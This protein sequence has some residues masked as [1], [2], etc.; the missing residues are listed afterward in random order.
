MTSW[1]P[2]QGQDYVGL[3]LSSSHVVQYREKGD[4]KMD[5]QNFFTNI[6]AGIACTAICAAIKRF[7]LYVKAS[8]EEINSPKNPSP[9]KTLQRQ[10]LVA[11]FLLALSLPAAF[12]LPVSRR[13]TMLGFIR[14]FLFF[15]AG[16]AFLIVWGAFDA[17]I[18]FYPGEDPRDDKPP[19]QA[20]NDAAQG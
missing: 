11:L 5:I 15:V 19:E 8:E 4:I 1:V 18:A 10:F 2:Y 7:F 9:R 17:A 6:I 14:I 12:M 16:I 20:A 3:V 13:P